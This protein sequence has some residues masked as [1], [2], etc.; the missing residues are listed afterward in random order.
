MPASDLIVTLFGLGVWGARIARALAAQGTTLDVVDPDADKQH[1]AMETGARSFKRRPDIAPDSQGI[2]IATPSTTHFALIK[3]L[4]HFGLPIFVEKPLTTDLKQARS[5]VGINSESVFVMHTW[6]YHPGIQLIAD[7]RKS[8][9]LGELLYLRT[10]RVNWTSPRKDTDSIWTLLPHDLVIA[11]A[12]LGTYPE[13]KYAAAEVHE[14]VPRGLVSIMGERPHVLIEISNRF[15][16]RGR[17]IRANFTG[18]SVWLKDEAT[19]YLEIA[20]GD[21]RVDAESARVVRRTFSLEPDPLTTQL[22]AFLRFLEGGPAPESSLKEGI[23]VVAQIDRIRK[24][25]HLPH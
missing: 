23:E 5:L 19:P 18:G 1:L 10:Q 11:R 4:V 6:L 25:A 15:W 20:F 17:E 24:L 12:I 22:L 3:E 8:G 16:Q 21:H 2:I 13:P 7:I 9:E 14:Q